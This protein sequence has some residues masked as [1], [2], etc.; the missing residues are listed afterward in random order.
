MAALRVRMTGAGLRA[1]SEVAGCAN[2]LILPQCLQILE[3]FG[4]A[5]RFTF[6]VAFRGEARVIAADDALFVYQD[7]FST[8][9]DFAQDVADVERSKRQLV[10]GFGGTG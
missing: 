1:R 6:R 4:D 3:Q 7:E 10:N 5:M 2:G 8:V 9:F